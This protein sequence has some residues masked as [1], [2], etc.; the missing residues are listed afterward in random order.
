MNY[1]NEMPEVGKKYRHHSCGVFIVAD[2]KDDLVHMLKD[3]SSCVYKVGLDYFSL[4][5]TKHKERKRGTDG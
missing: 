5:F 3:K 2:V 4:Y 1:F